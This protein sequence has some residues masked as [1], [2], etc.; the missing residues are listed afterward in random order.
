MPSLKIE[1]KSAPE[2]K[3]LINRILPEYRKHNVYL[4]EFHPQSINS[5]WD[6]GSKTYY[7]LVD[8]STMKTAPLPTSTHPFFDVARY[9]VRGESEAVSVDHAGNITLKVLPENFAL[10]TSGIFCGKPGTAH[11]YLNP[12]NM[13]KLLPSAWEV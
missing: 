2:V 13:T 3:R 11:I 7:T 6:G 10:I 5:Y 8:L 9:G 1:L 4:S 12:A